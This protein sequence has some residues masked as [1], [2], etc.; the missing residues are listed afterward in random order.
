MVSHYLLQWIQA[1]EHM[2]YTSTLNKGQTERNYTEHTISLIVFGLVAGNKRTAQKYVYVKKRYQI[3][4]SQA[5]TLP[6]SYTTSKGDKSSSL[7]CDK[8]K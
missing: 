7:R 3:M 4:V 6:S 5:R 8:T 2:L 1:L